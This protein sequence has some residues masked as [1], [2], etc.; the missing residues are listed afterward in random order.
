MNPERDDIS[1]EMKEW[2]INNML[3]CMKRPIA[4]T[5]NVEHTPVSFCKD[6]YNVRC[7]NTASNGNFPFAIFCSAAENLELR[8]EFDFQL[9][10]EWE[11]SWRNIYLKT[12]HGHQ[13]H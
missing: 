9:L 4:S 10:K 2:C 11:I 12:K 3:R 1:L 7:L 13:V 6:S 8:K 5:R